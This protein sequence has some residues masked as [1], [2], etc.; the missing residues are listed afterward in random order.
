MKL[1]YTKMFAVWFTVGTALA[2]LL[3]VV[4]PTVLDKW[5]YQSY[6]N[7]NYIFKFLLLKYRY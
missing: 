3:F 1:S 4:T 2:F 6:Y 7:Q 5:N